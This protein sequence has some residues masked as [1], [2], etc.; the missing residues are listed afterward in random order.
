MDYINRYTEDMLVEAPEEPGTPFHPFN[1]ADAPAIASY[2]I[3]EPSNIQKV[4][5]PQ[6]EHRLNL[7]NIWEIPAGSRVLEVGCGQG[8][9][10]SV[11]ASIVGPEGKVDALDPASLNYG[12]PWT[13]GQAQAHLSETEIGSRIH[14]WNMSL[15][16]FLKRENFSNWDYVVFSHCIW[17]FDSPELLTEM[18]KLVKHRARRVLVAEYALKATKKEAEPHLLAAIARASLEAHNK[19]SEANIRCMLGPAAIRE[20]IE[21]AGYKFEKEDH[22]VP[23]VGLLDG[24]WETGDVKHEQFLK[25]VETHIKDERVKTMLRSSREAVIA[26]VAAL[27]D[28][29]VHTMDVWAARFTRD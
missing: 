6:T 27:G 10:T 15:P 18:L 19:E 9:T 2:A 4:E 5:I 25:D 12:S 17:Y 3:G 22:L 1:K 29:K 24:A 14:W 7:V 8:T 13:L 11:L 16:T 26:A 20:A 23:E 21:A 28:R